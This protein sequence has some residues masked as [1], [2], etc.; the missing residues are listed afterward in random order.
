MLVFPFFL[1]T[2]RQAKE[3]VEKAETNLQQQRWSDQYLR[4]T[5]RAQYYEA[6]WDY[7]WIDPP[8]PT[9]ET[10]ASPVEPIGTFQESS[11]KSFDVYKFSDF[12]TLL[13]EEYS[14]KR[15]YN[16]AVKSIDMYEWV[17]SPWSKYTHVDF[18]SFSL[19]KLSLD[20]G[21]D[22]VVEMDDGVDPGESAQ[23]YVLFKAE[24][25]KY[26]NAAGL[27]KIQVTNTSD[28]RDEAYDC[29]IKYV[30][31]GP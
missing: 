1:S 6:Y 31:D 24:D 7:E 27:L 25:T 8:E 9:R 4:I 18:I 22:Y 19:D 3:K 12:G 17:G 10:E 28:T 13:E 5:F 29:T 21:K 15:S 11:K 30:T 14:L 23:F 16:E 20:G 26:G 2:L